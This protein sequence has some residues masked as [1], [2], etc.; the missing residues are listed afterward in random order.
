M[1]LNSFSTTTTIIALRVRVSVRVKMFYVYSLTLPFSSYFT[2]Y[3][4]KR[5]IL[6]SWVII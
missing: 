1:K 5:F 6:A 2:K 4:F 3:S